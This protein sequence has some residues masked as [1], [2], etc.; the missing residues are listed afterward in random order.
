MAEN[1]VILRCHLRV[2]IGEHVR[3]VQVG[4]EAV[5]SSAFRTYREPMVVLRNFD[6]F[7]KIVIPC[8]VLA[9]V[10]HRYVLAACL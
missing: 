5:A 10:R 9:L 3:S 4:M 2:T 7:Q 1:T 8:A 6:A